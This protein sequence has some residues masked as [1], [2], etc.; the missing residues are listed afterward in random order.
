MLEDVI[1]IIRNVSLRHKAV[2]TFKYQD[3]ML[4]NAQGS[5]RYFQVVVDDTNLSQLLISYSPDVFTITLDV[6]ILGFVPTSGS[7]LDIQSQA[8]DIAIQII[9][10]VESLEEYKNIIDI[11]DYSIL[12]LSHYTDDDS[13]G[14]KM[15]LEMRVP[16]GVCDLDDYF[17]DEPTDMTEEDTEINLSGS[18][19]NDR[20]ITLNP[21]SVPTNTGTTNNCCKC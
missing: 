13:A 4:T 1:N 5:N 10:K 3:S 2:N 21:I 20:T 9:K 8:Y 18:T 6:Y 7:I 12:T 15:S 19:S 16:I 11:H 14:V 17:D